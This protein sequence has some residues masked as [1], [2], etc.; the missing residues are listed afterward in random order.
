MLP[1]LTFLW[2]LLFPEECNLTSPYVYNLV[3]P[4][5]HSVSF[6][7]WPLHCLHKS[8]FVNAYLVDLNFIVTVKDHGKAFLKYIDHCDLLTFIL[9]YYR[10]TSDLSTL[11]FFYAQILEIV[12]L[13]DVAVKD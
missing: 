12:E 5:P 13:L 2:I 1:Q 10:T 11:V 9:R 8:Q 6:L 7:P 3:I 4:Q